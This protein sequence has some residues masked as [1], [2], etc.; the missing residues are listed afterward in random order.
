MIKIGFYIKE[1][2]KSVFRNR[3]TSIAT[4]L[5]MTLTLLILGITLL[6]ILNLD[7][8]VLSARQEFSGI[9]IFLKNEVD[10]SMM[11]DFENKLRDNQ[12]LKDIIFVSKDET[13]ESFK[14][15]I[16]YETDIFS[17]IENPCENSFIV[18]PNDAKDSADIVEELKKDKRVSSISFYQDTIEQLVKISNIAGLISIIVIVVLFVFSLL[19]IEN[20]IKITIFSRM[21]EINIMKVI[22]ATNWFIRW[23]FILE[24][25]LLGFIGSFSAFLIT[26]FAYAKVYSILS[27]TIFFS[28]YIVDKATMSSLLL[29]LFVLTGIGIGILGSVSSLRKYLKV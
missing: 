15:N 10:K 14:N 3:N 7:K 26:D 25:A 29:S 13:M 21:R 5:S 11:D 19:I 2:F 12:L 17:D 4:I 27:G 20:M 24:G 6:I 9:Q 23:P 22:G 8:F 28:K 16:G 18:Y 1:T